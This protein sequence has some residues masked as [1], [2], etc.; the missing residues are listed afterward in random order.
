MRGVALSLLSATVLS[1]AA[2]GG[3]KLRAIAQSLPP[4]A[5]LSETRSHAVTTVVSSDGVLLATFETQYRRP[6]SLEQISPLLIDATLATEDA[7]FYD[8]AGVDPRGVLRAALCNLLSKN[9]SGQG[10]ST[11]TQQLARNLYLSSEKTVRRKIEEAMLAVEIEHRYSK[12]DIL[13]AYFNTIYFGNGC[14]GAEA[15]ARAYFHKPARDLDLGE[16]SLLAGLP[17]RPAAYSPIQHLPE[18]L[19]RRSEVLARMAA[20]GK[21]SRLDADSAAR[22]H[23]RLYRPHLQS[24]A[25]WKAPYFVQHVLDCLRDRLGAESL[26]S[27]LRIVTT[28]NWRMQRAAE[29]SLQSGIRRRLGPTTGAVV[30]LDP[31]SGAIRAMVGGADFQRD[32]FN[33]ATQGVRQPGSAFKPFV[34]AAAFDANVVD[35]ASTLDDKKLVYP[36]YPRDWVVHNYGDHYK[37]TVSVLEAIRQSINTIAVQ[38]AEQT[39]PSTIQAYARQLG[40]STP[41][42]PDLPLSL[43][44][45]GVHPIDLCSAYS[46]FANCGARF[47]PYSVQQVSDAQ[48]R[49]LYA[50]DP[51][52]RLHDSFMNVATVDQINVALR[53]VVIN[54]T[55]TG[56]ADVPDA[57][58][59]TGTTTSHR[60]AWFVGYTARLVTAV[61]MAHPSRL[62][63]L[64]GRTVTNYLPMPG[65]PGGQLCAPLWRRFMLQALPIQAHVDRAHNIGEPLIVQPERNAL[66]AQL[67]SEV[68][69]TGLE[70]AKR[71]ESIATS[72]DD[73]SGHLWIE[74]AYPP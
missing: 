73:G 2:Y 70:E 23:V 43:G 1:A 32:Q 71:A 50:D 35:L 17:Q 10:G 3:L 45:S 16:A 7:R 28:M 67:Q 21:I 46:A 62:Q 8:H 37:G 49:E 60:D 30:C 34:Y 12:H 26:Y 13:E 66:M 6:V 56:A 57:H 27:G 63:G 38:V 69:N 18:A 22:Q 11:I 5:K 41:M 54:G 14:Y 19:H 39:G 36:Q 55:A 61:W 31:R 74:G 24:Q 68:P 59:K 48:G 25:D 33:A 9:P 40:I 15:A 72:G 52:P 29:E 53:E 4:I 64:D 44:A 58:G 47:D 42:T 51:A 65:A 20:C